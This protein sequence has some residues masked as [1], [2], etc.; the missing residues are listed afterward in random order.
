MG[1]DQ[2][3]VKGNVRLVLLPLLTH[4]GG[5]LVL[6]REDNAW[7]VLRVGGGVCLCNQLVHL[8]QHQ[9]LELGR[10]DSDGVEFAPQRLDL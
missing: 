7:V 6:D 2:R 9:V 8:A 5:I 1:S 4:L 10:R 3:V